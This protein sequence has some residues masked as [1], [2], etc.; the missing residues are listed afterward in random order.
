MTETN[1]HPAIIYFPFSVRDTIVTAVKTFYN[2]YKGKKNQHLCYNLGDKDK[3]FLSICA[4]LIQFG[5]FRDRDKTLTSAQSSS[6]GTRKSFLL[7]GR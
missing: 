1:K 4:V 2:K 7:L 3:H 5:K 6:S